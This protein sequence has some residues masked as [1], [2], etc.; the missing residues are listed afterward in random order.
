[1]SGTAILWASRTLSALTGLFLL[2]DGVM[3]LVRPA[4]VLATFQPLG[5]PES[6]SIPLGILLLVCTVLYLIPK[7]AVLGAVLL[8]GYL[9]G[10]AAIHLRVGNPLF[11]H[12][13][14][15][16]YVGVLLWLALWLRVPALRALLPLTDR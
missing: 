7:T 5:L 10:A 6:L 2:V 8:T 3:K 4:P 12:V 15:S 16:V 9:G 13:L 14:F 11:S 1:M